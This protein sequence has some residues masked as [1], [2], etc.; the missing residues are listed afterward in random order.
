MTDERKEKIK[1]ETELLR[2]LV[3]APG[4]LPVADRLV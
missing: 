2:Y 4:S 3:L 1:L